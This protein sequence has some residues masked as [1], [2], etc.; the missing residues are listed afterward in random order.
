MRCSLIIIFTF[1]MGWPRVRKWA[2]KKACHNILCY[3]NKNGNR[4]FHNK[5][6]VWMLQYFSNDFIIQIFDCTCDEKKLRSGVYHRYNV[7]IRL[8]HIL[9][10][11]EIER[12]LFI[13]CLNYSK[14]I[15]LIRSFGI[16]KPLWLILYVTEIKLRIQG[17]S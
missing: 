4:K 15:W 3:W 16:L 14:I 7:I 5:N 11:C 1:A 12:F 13:A 6:I 2:R 9:K 10:N 17:D 8:K